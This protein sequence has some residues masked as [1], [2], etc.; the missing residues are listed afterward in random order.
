MIDPLFAIIRSRDV[1]GT[2]RMALIVWLYQITLALRMA[3][4]LAAESGS[5]LQAVD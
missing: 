5:A 2:L 3:P 1:D 4:L